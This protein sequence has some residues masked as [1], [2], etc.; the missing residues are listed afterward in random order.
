LR[1]VGGAGAL[2]AREIIGWEHFPGKMLLAI[3]LA[4]IS[5]SGGNAC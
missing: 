5:G 2:N 1:K 4:G 3:L